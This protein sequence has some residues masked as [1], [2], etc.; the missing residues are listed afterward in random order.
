MPT[1][2]QFLGWLEVIRQELVFITG[3][4]DSVALASLIEGI[5]FQLTG[6]T[7]VQGELGALGGGLCRSQNGRAGGLRTDGQGEQLAPH[8]ATSSACPACVRVYAQ[9]RRRGARKRTPSSRC[10]AASSS[11]TPVSYH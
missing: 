3:D 10:T 11:S 5:K 4:A 6:E 8:S 1:D 7:P 2:L 9:A